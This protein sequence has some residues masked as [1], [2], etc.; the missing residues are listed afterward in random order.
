M[1]TKCATDIDSPLAFFLTVLLSYAPSC[2]AKVLSAW[3]A[4]SV[5]N[6]VCADVNTGGGGVGVSA[7]K[8][9]SNTICICSSDNVGCVTPAVRSFNSSSSCA[10]VS[11]SPGQ[12]T[13]SQSIGFLSQ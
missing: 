11:S 13:Y 5:I 7:Q 4:C 8:A 9:S 12:G 2:S 6:T 10:R 3:V 1:K